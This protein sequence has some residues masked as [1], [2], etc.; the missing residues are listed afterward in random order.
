[1]PSVAR[2]MPTCLSHQST[3][4]INHPLPTHTVA[5]LWGSCSSQSPSQG[6]GGSCWD[7][8]GLSR[9]SREVAGCSDSRWAS[10]TGCR[11]QPFSLPCP[12]K[13][14]GGG[15]S[16]SGV[17]HF[18]KRDGIRR[19]AFPSDAGEVTGPL[20]LRIP[21]LSVSKRLGHTMKSVSRG[22][23]PQ[24]LGSHMDL[25]WA[26]DTMFHTAA[27][28]PH[29]FCPTP[30]TPHPAALLPL[31]VWVHHTLPLFPVSGQG[32]RGKGHLVSGHASWWPLPA[33][34]PLGLPFALVP[35]RQN[36]LSFSHF[37]TS[38]LSSF[39]PPLP[40]VIPTL[41]FLVDPS[42]LP[43][44]L[45][46]TPAPCHGPSH[47]ESPSCSSTCARNPIKLPRPDLLS[48]APVLRE[49]PSSCLGESIA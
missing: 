48:Q 33:S 8:P 23:F 30:N 47:S 37:S 11:A 25:S 14:L 4:T 3:Q 16:A 28:D 32:S 22:S 29:Y 15:V 20:I 38:C 24:G 12:L 26:L 46:L 35:T 10:W 34:S 45:N 43:G 21:V 18:L 44:P 7:P 40:P 41:L 17:S 49:L 19:L 5:V 2:K 6:L 31:S 27:L 39:S 1:M 42:H 9:L 36:F 13:G